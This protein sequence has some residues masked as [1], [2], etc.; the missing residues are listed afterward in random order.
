[1]NRLLTPFFA[2]L[3]YLAGSCWTICSAA[4]VTIYFY[5]PET[6]IDNFATLKTAFDSYLSTQGSYSLQPFD[7]QN[8]FENII[9]QPKNGNVYLLSSWHLD[10]LQKQKYPLEVV[11]MG[12][13]KGIS[14]Q[15]KI[16]SAKKE[17]TDFNMLKNSTIAGAGTEEYIRNVL[18][19]ITKQ[20]LPDT[21][22]ILSVPKDIDALMAVGFGVATAAISTEGSFNKLA[23]INPNQ[24]QQL[25]VLGASEKS[26]FLVAATL[27]KPGRDETQ[28]LEILYK[29]SEK[30]AGQKSLNLLGLDGWKWK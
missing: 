17:I 7:N 28:V 10:V 15:S 13:S 11:L 3:L 21:I 22:K 4:G 27:E 25:H 20:K 19:R 30:E 23:A 14:M 18:Q 1:M 9:K 5:N 24:Y 2:L 26:Y 29:M 8:S 16:L 12:T 6:S